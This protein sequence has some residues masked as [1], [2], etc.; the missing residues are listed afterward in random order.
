MFSG[1]GG[2]KKVRVRAVP[3]L[4]CLLLPVSP[5]LFLGLQNLVEEEWILLHHNKHDAL[6]RP[7][8]TNVLNL[9]PTVI[10]EHIQ[11]ITLFIATELTTILSIISCSLLPLMAASPLSL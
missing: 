4:H 2:G 5:G 9:Y 3:F 6:A 8:T 7:V 11:D 1:L 10:K